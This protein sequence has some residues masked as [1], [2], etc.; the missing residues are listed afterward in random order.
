MGVH[1][2]CYDGVA[3]VVDLGPKASVTAAA[4]AVTL[5]DARILSE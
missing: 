4:S 2:A 5:Q 1:L 3:A